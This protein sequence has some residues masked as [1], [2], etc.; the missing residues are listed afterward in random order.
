MG[1]KLLQLYL[2]EEI[3]SLDVKE[4]N[5]YKSVMRKTYGRDVYTVFF[6]KLYSFILMQKNSLYILMP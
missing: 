4:F 2:F 5:Y 1:N 3:R 6:L